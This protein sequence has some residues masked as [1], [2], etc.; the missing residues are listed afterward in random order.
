M[1]K[2]RSGKLACIVAV[3]C[4][5]GSVVSPAQ[6]YTK[7]VNF[8]GVHGAG[9]YGPLVQGPNGNLYGVTNSGGV[10]SH[11]PNSLGCG[12]VFE[13]TPE[14]KL[15]FIHDFCQLA[16]CADGASPSSGLVLATNGNFYG[17]TPEIV[18]GGGTIF[19]ITPTGKFT[20]LY[21]FCLAEN[22]PDGKGPIGRLMQ[23][24]NGNLYGATTGGGDSMHCAGGC[25]TIFQ[26]TLSGTFSIFHAFC[27]TTECTHDGRNPRTGLIQ[28]TNG[29]YI[30]TTSGGGVSQVGIVYEITPGGKLTQLYNFCSQLHCT[31]GDSAGAPPIQAA[32]GNLY[33]TTLGGGI[34][35]GGLFYELTLAKQFTDLYDFCSQKIGIACAD[36]D[37]PSGLVQGTNGN[38][39]A[40]APIGGTSSLC[41]TGIG[42]GVLFELTP[43]GGYTLLYDFCSLANCT[44]GGSP[45]GGLMQATN[46]MFYGTDGIGGS[47]S[48]C[49]QG[50]GCGAIYT[51]SVGLG[52][53]VE[54]LPGFGSAGRVVGILGSQLGA[55]TSV[56][57]NGTAATFTVVSN[58]LIKA[59]VP[60][61]ATTGTIEVTTP[62]GTLS[63][64]AVFL[65]E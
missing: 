55:T 41:G 58:T 60:A 3:F 53:F 36:G 52:P 19:E 63:S 61:G 10:S 38:F 13:V 50:L 20:S 14:G 24:A 23:A 46:G 25:G 51:L 65:V 7:L 43:A 30:G 35:G 34:N 9:P 2:I 26:I 32:D 18:G 16:K 1:R 5:A 33:G 44:D 21:T 8:D 31:D 6:T 49:P 40:S 45:T 62:S 11:C 64:N 27:S 29:N 54:A 39:Y 56:T 17:M 28:A 12:T 4:L 22:C 57:F 59:T 15:T 37:N 42:C 48:G 47:G